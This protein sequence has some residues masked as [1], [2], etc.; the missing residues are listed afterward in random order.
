MPLNPANPLF[1]L[2]QASPLPVFPA[3]GYVVVGYTQRQLPV[4][5]A[6]FSGQR[7][8]QTYIATVT[9]LVAAGQW[10]HSL[11]EDNPRKDMQSLAPFQGY[12]VFTTSMTSPDGDI[13]YKHGDYFVPSGAVVGLVANTQHPIR[14]VMSRPGFYELTIER[15]L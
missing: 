3:S 12:R 5:P 10:L 4:V 9:V 8:V 13:P 15:K 7:A 14:G 6:S 2:G 11:V 1:P